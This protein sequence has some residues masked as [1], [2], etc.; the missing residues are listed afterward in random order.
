MDWPE[1]VERVSAV[2]REAGA[3]ARVEEFAE[4]TPTA[5]DAANAVGCDLSQI[6]KSLVFDCDGRASARDGPGRPPRRQGQG[7][8][9]ASAPRRHAWRARSWS[10]RRRAIRPAGLRR[11]GC[12]QWSGSLIDTA[13]ARQR[14]VWVGAGSRR[15]MAGL[16]ATELVRVARAAAV[17]CHRGRVKSRGKERNAG[18]REDLDE[19]RARRTGRTRRST[20]ARTACTTAPASSRASA[21][22]TPTRG[23]RSSA[24]PTT[25][26]R[27]AHL[28]QPDLH[29][30]ARTRSTSCAP[31]CLETIARER[32]RRVL[33]PPDRVLRRTASSA[34]TR[35][36][37]RSTSRS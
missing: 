31:P 8:C 17:R 33:P 35:G 3:E 1:P 21:A 36:R 24:S 6:V 16:P 22:T 5:E 37:T 2:L 26:Q 4:G 30:A 32:A 29:G 28:G 11:S 23:P 34:S 10:W 9:C 12:G 18:D 15:H 14:D 7:R 13:P 27:L 20:S 25:S 19:R